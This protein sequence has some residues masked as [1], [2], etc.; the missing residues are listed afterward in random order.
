MTLPIDAIRERA[1]KAERRDALT[2]ARDSLYSQ[3][4]EVVNKAGALRRFIG[5]QSAVHGY[6]ALVADLDAGEQAI[7]GA[8]IQAVDSLV[9]NDTTSDEP[10]PTIYQEP[11]PQGG[12]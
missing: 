6:P 4:A 5:T 2:I 7:I 3:V 12:E 8:I 10:L 11:Q 1:A 9:S